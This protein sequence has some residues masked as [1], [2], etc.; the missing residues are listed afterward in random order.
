MA[1]VIASGALKWSGIL[2]ARRKLVKPKKKGATAE[3]CARR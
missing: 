3:G 1:S 2:A